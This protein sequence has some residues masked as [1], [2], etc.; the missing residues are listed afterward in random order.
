MKKIISGI[1]IITAMIVTACNNGGPENNHVGHDMTK[2][3]APKQQHSSASDE[4]E[5][6]PLTVAFNQVDGKAA[7][8]I[9]EIVEH[10]L[11]TKNALANDNANEAAKEGKSIV[12]S[13][14]KLD[15]SLLTVA[16]KEVF[17]QYSDQLE[18]S[19]VK[20][21][22]TAG[23]IALQR[24]H[25]VDMSEGIYAMVKA[26]GGGR[27]VYH[28]HC[29]MAQDNK[30]AMWISETKEIRNPYFGEKMISCGTIKEVIQ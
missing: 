4:M 9:K 6:K 23:D 16:Q 7:A 30:G 27:P 19:A 25:F 28:A 10:Y 29:P 3:E 15:K 21:S 13:M 5:V 17:E 8:T 1:T 12:T 24:Q 26:F 18:T 22:E 20:I 11:Q 2:M 14:G